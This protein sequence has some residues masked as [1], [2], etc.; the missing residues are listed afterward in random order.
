MELQ[1]DRILPRGSTANLVDLQAI[2]NLSATEFAV[3]VGREATVK[4][5]AETKTRL[6]PQT[7]TGEI[8]KGNKEEE[9]E[10]EQ[11]EEAQKGG[12]T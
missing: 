3:S 11:E 12:R 8:W 10:K 6:L 5:G 2:G 7:R 9:E 4:I 1:G